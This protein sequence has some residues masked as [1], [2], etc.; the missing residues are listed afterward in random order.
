MLPPTVPLAG[1]CTTLSTPLQNISPGCS[2]TDQRTNQQVWDFFKLPMPNV[3]TLGDDLLSTMA[4]STHTQY[5]ESNQYG[6][7]DLVTSPP[8]ASDL[9]ENS[10]EP[11]REYVPDAVGSQRRNPLGENV[12][13]VGRTAKLSMS[14]LARIL[15]TSPDMLRRCTEKTTHALSTFFSNQSAP[16]EENGK[17]IAT[18]TLYIK[19]LKELGVIDGL[20]YDQVLGGSLELQVSKEYY[21]TS[22]VTHIVMSRLDS[23][24]PF[25]F[26]Y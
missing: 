5:L 15:P 1:Q 24:S 26:I 13:T 12:K 20:H 11:D 18:K 3:H 14:Q 4:N 2:G 19:L 10:S 9:N 25:R 8:M 6:W 22:V 16:T 23:N 21:K 7:T 17:K